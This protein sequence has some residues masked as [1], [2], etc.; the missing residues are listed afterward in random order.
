MLG[1]QVVVQLLQEIRGIGIVSD[2]LPR[3]PFRP[4]RTQKPPRDA[5][6]CVERGI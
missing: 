4:V 6:V 5:S 3:N 2:L 1:F